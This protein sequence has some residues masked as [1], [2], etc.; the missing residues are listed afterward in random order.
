MI[1]IWL[2]LLLLVS[3]S[4]FSKANTCKGLMDATLRVDVKLS[5][6]PQAL[7]LSTNKD[8][9]FKESDSAKIKEVISQNFI[10]TEAEILNLQANGGKS[11][12]LIKLIDLILEK[13]DSQ[14]VDISEKSTKIAKLYSEVFKPMINEFEMEQQKPAKFTFAKAII[15]IESF[16]PTEFTENGALALTGK[17]MLYAHVG[18]FYEMTKSY[19]EKTAPYT[20]VPIN[21]RSVLVFKDIRDI[22][23]HN[24]FPLEFK[25]HDARHMHYSTGHPYSIGLVWSAARTKNHIR[26]ILVSGLFEGVDTAQYGWE[27]NI[28]NH[29]REKSLNLEEALIEIGLMNQIELT[30]LAT[31]TAAIGKLTDFESWTPTNNGIFTVQGRSGKGLNAELSTAMEKLFLVLK[32]PEESKYTNYSRDPFSSIPTESDHTIH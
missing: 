11:V 8:I 24:Y 4:S 3:Y 32:N 28:T 20:E 19:I 7:K 18:D 26:Y 22:E 6:M 27:R 12:N 30:E 2:L 13:L 9:N 10:V 29:F 23:S 15:D 31:K 5:A 16:K 17:R 21:G 1:R 14:N 25:G